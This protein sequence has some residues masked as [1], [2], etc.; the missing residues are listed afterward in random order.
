MIRKV[1]TETI[2]YNI[3]L[4]TE[5][6]EV[7]K[8]VVLNPNERTIVESSLPQLNEEYINKTLLEVNR[9]LVN[10]NTYVSEDLTKKILDALENRQ[11][12]RLPY[13]VDNKIVFKVD[14][15]DP[16]N[17]FPNIYL[18]NLNN[19]ASAEY[20]AKPNII[21]IDGLDNKGDI[22]SYKLEEFKKNAL[23]TISHELKH[24]DTFELFNS[25]DKLKTYA[26]DDKKPDTKKFKEIEAFKQQL[27]TLT[28]MNFNTTIKEVMRKDPNK[29]LQQIFSDTVNEIITKKFKENTQLG[30][31]LNNISEKDKK[32]IYQYIYSQAK[33]TFLDYY[34][35][36]VDYHSQAKNGTL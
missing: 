6:K 13:I 2:L 23:S 22:D 10:Y 15:N 36:F 16:N 14:I 26:N 7:Y 11:Y 25:I 12:H 8:R 32:A 17:E 31:F 19:Y 28:K 5:F 1:I 20:N 30:S 21:S 9:D 34:Y 24:K 27:S 3:N 33:E 4:P 18:M 35:T 29:S